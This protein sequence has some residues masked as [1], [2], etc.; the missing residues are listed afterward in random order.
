MSKLIPASFA[1]L[2]DHWHTV[3]TGTSD[4]TDLIGINPNTLKTRLARHQ[5]LTMRDDDNAQRGPL[6]F[7]GYHLVY[8]IIAD[9]LLRYGLSIDAMGEDTDDPNKQGWIAHCYAQWVH[10]EILTGAQHVNTIFRCKKLADGKTQIHVYEDGGYEVEFLKGRDRP[11][12]I[13]VEAADVE[14]LALAGDEHDPHGR[15][16]RDHGRITGAVEPF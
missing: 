16:S 2:S 9:R 7:T 14:A 8:N 3:L 5:A 4:A 6:R 1:F 10:D 12:V 11:A 15:H 13:T